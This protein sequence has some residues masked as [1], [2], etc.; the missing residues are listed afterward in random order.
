[1]ADIGK[2]IKKRREE[3]GLTQGEL[4]LKLGYRSKTTIAKIENGTNDIV[5]SKVIDFAKALDT[6]PAFLM[7]WSENEEK[8]LNTITHG[9]EQIVN[10][11]N[12][13]IQLFETYGYKIILEPDTVKVSTKDGQNFSISRKDF[14]SMI[15]RCHKDINYNFDRLIDE[16]KRSEYLAV[17]A[18]HDDPNATAEEKAASDAIM[19]DDKEWE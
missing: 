5:Q 14:M 16:Y 11:T 10:R 6:T 19:Y 12:L 2:R 13:Y 15:Q 17:N 18:A 4:A 7:G 8:A 1:M 3:L 9:L